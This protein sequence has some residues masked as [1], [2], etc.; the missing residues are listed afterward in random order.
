[1]KN[2]MLLLFPLLALGQSSFDTAVSYFDSNDFD[3]ARV[4]FERHLAQDKDLRTIEYLGDIAGYSKDWDKAMAY[5]QELLEAQPD[6]A[7]Y[8]FKY[9]GALGMK[10]LEVN[11]LRAA[12]YIGDIKKHFHRAAEL[13]PSHI[14]ARWALVELYMQ[15]P[16]IIGG[17]EE[18]SLAYAEELAGI[19]PVDGWLAKG[20]IAE[21]SNR[22]QEAEA[23]YKKA[24]EVGQ[25]PHT[26]DKLSE[27]YE[28]NN[29]PREALETARVS[30]EKHKRNSLNYQI[31]KIAAQY[32]IEPETGIKCLMEYIEKYTVKD[33]VPKDWAY[34]RL[35]QIYRNMGN[36]Q[37]A[38]SWIDK[39]LND[40]PDFEQ[41]REE[42]ERIEA[43]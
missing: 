31:G 11:K 18:K 14:E 33:G 20:Y 16:G 12:T 38:L 13:D 40:R 32:N 10:A 42:K 17:S 35:A 5:Y 1:M 39:A 3:K 36:K 34:Y 2:L 21:Y 23:F 24:V 4:Y 8:N 28:K 9:G 37:Q 7:N 15:L 25:S 22:P 43:L 30:L 29:R 27:H 6:N 26:Y 19:S 41:A